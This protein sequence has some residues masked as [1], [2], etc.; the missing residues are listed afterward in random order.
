[1]K[2]YVQTLLG[3]SLEFL[4]VSELTRAKRILNERKYWNSVNNMPLSQRSLHKEMHL[5]QEL[6]MQFM[7]QMDMKANLNKKVE[8]LKNL[9]HLAG[10]KVALIT[11]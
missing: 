8:T 6:M 10:F 2:E 5:L 7:E 9:T 1:M 3:N 11:S 4:G